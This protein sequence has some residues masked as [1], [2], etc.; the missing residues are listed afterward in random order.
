MSLPVS[1][2]L[3][4]PIYFVQ[5]NLTFN[6]GS[7]LIG[8]SHQ[9][10]AD[11]GYKSATLTVAIAASEVGYWLR[12]GLG[13]HVEA[14]CGTVKVWE[15][16]VD[17]LAL[18]I[19]SLAVTRGPLL[20][21]G[22]RVTARYT[23]PTVGQQANT[24]AANNTDSQAVYGIHHKVISAGTVSPTNGDK[25]RDSYLQE[26]K[27]PE[28]SI[29]VSFQGNDVGL[30]LN[31]LGY[32]E[33]LKYPYNEIT[34]TTYT[35]R[36]KILEVL[37]DD[38]NGIFS[39][40]YNFIEANTLSVYRLDNEY[41][42][43]ETVLAEIIAM[44]NHEAATSGGNDRRT[45]QVYDDRTIYIQKT[46]TVIHYKVRVF[47]PA[48]AILDETA[49]PIDPSTIKAGQWLQIIDFPNIEPASTPS[50]YTTPDLRTDPRMIFI[51][52]VTYTAPYDFSINGGKTGRLAQ[53]LAKLG[54]SGG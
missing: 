15:G 6:L 17:S 33:W 16:F 48:K 29:T 32:V 35:A 5:R 26:N 30:T 51:E 4:D 31:C 54:V 45:L 22:N 49:S 52:S 13:K 46:P 43:A 20:D 19:G 11:G 14:F 12:H 36:E 25:I 1:V 28:T 24:T 23:D 38:P 44:G 40:N 21:I 42:L 3:S 53:Q 8:Y 18:N 10:A 39:T 41:R 37:S 50:G 9:N 47:D 34:D 27:L 2:T 7:A